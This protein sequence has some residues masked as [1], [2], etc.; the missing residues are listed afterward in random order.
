MVQKYLSLLHRLKIPY[1]DSFKMLFKSS[2]FE[3]Y[4]LLSNKLERI[5]LK[6]KHDEY[7]KYKEKKINRLTETY[8]A[9]N[10]E[11]LFLELYEILQTADKNSVWQI[12]Q[13]IVSIFEELSKRD[14]SL[15]GEVVKQY[16]EKNDYLKLNPWMVV[17]ELVSSCGAVVS[18]EIISS[19]NY[20]SK[21][22][23]LFS[24]FQHIEQEDVRLEFLVELEMLYSTSDYEYFINNLD[25]LLKY[26]LVEKGFVVKIIKVIV[27]RI[28]REPI[29]AHALSML[30]NKHTELYK[31]IFSLLSSDINLIENAFLEVDKVEQNLDYDGAMFAKLLSNDVGFLKNI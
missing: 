18:Y 12:E 10:Y 23:W 2:T 6:L 9:N 4:D 25:Y 30:F 26:E 19:T 31:Q 5:E 22:R 11:K 24:Y 1:E 28:S 21:N 7:Q 3:L 17:R 27:S 15:Y 20:E 14:S 13:G 29:F 16:L 8:N